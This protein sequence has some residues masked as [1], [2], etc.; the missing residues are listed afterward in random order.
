MGAQRHGTNLSS[1]SQSSESAESNR[2]T[3]LNSQLH[4]TKFCSF[5]LKGMC[6]FGANCSFAHSSSELQATPDLQQTKLCANITEGRGCTDPSCTF[7]HSEDELRS[8][9]MFFK[10]TLCVWHEKGKCRNGNQCRFAH[11]LVELRANFATLAYGMQAKDAVPKK[12]EANK[13][14]PIRAAESLKD[15]PRF[16]PEGAETLLPMPMKILPSSFDLKTGNFSKANDLQLDAQLAMLHWKLSALAARCNQMN[17]HLLPL[18]E[19]KDD[20]SFLL[21]KLWEASFFEG[22][23]MQV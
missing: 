4:K 12:A 17:Q 19:V 11:G 21:S 20:E 10:K 23:C 13:G 14:S 18:L 1:A 7:A 5:H 9:D 6:R 15:K 2:Q 16:R 22:K 3:C 8:T